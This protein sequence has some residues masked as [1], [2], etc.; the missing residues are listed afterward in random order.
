MS[1]GGF[2]PIFKQ[3]TS[4]LHLLIQKT[5]H[6]SLHYERR[7]YVWDTTAWEF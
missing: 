5:R 1:T 6:S 2:Y 4:D 3:N 7:Q